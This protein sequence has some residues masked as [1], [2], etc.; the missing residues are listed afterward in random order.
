MSPPKA[1]PS[2]RQFQPSTASWL[3]PHNLNSV[4]DLH[5]P[6]LLQQPR[7]DSAELPGRAALWEPGSDP[8]NPPPRPPLRH[9]GNSLGT[10][11]GALPRP[12]LK[13]KLTHAQWVH[14]NLNRVLEERVLLRCLRSEVLSL[15]RWLVTQRMRRAL[16]TT[17]KLRQ[18]LSRHL[19][20]T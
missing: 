13:G 4:G 11:P 15:S 10:L 8:L 17:K 1:P 3:H 6:H 7:H 14:Q 2:P 19:H 9:L 16:Q 12:F 20:L 18:S 5:P